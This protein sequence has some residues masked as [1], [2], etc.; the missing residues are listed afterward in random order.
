MYLFGQWSDKSLAIYYLRG[1]WSAY[2]L[3][4][5]PFVFGTSV[6]ALMRLSMILISF[7]VTSNCGGRG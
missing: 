6:N 5:K 7:S 1:K 4:N 3:Y 2:L